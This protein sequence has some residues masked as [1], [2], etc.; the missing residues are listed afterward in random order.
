MMYIARHEW[1][2]FFRTPFGWVLLGLS[3]VILGLAYYILLNNY[4]QK[5][6]FAVPGRG[7]SY[8]VV[9]LLVAIL[10]YLALFIVPLAASRLIAYERRQNTL[11]LYLLSPTSTWQIVLGKYLGLFAFVACLLVP[12]VA[13]ALLLGLSSQL[14]W[15]VVMASLLAGALLLAAY[16][17]I[18]LFC[19]SVFRQP[20]LAGL[21]ASL[22]LLAFILLDLLADTRIDWLDQALAFVS[23]VRHFE[24]LLNGLIR[25]GDVAFFAWL[26]LLFLGLSYWQIRR[27][28][29][30]RCN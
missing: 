4:Y 5:L 25:I 7:I 17:A 14:D 9:G 15:G 3:Q 16:S 21:I 13:V 29:F 30:A 6:K 19:S 8:E 2:Q 1:L 24:A 10:L 18:A 11:A 26:A 12:V 22:I 28:R 27:L 23:I 20:L